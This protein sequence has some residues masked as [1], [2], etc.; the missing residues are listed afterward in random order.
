MHTFRSPLGLCDLVYARIKNV[1]MQAHGSIPY[2]MDKK[3][4]KS[5]FDI[6]FGYRLLKD[7][8]VVIALTKIEAQQ[9]VDIGVPKDKIKIVPN[10]IDI[11]NEYDNLPRK[12]IFRQRY[13]VSN[14]EKLILYL[15]RIHKIK[16]LILLIEAF[17]DLTDDLVNAKLAIV[18]PDDSYLSE[19]NQEIASYT[20][21]DKIFFTGPLYGSEK[22]KQRDAIYMFYHL[23]T[24]RPINSSRSDCLRSPVIVTGKIVVY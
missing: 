15:G 20:V 21:G 22:L 6:L 12:G 14:D 13:N 9:Y 18:G 2:I 7:A 11:D 24:K 8:S 3:A 19:L 17:K 4:T 10:G 16:G 1:Y 23:F 5:L